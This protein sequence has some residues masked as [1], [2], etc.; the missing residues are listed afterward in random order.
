MIQKKE[1]IDMCNGKTNSDLIDI[2]LWLEQALILQKIMN[3]GREAEIVYNMKYML[4]CI[5][6]GW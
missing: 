6:S 1:L 2:K 3:I 5:R 4:A